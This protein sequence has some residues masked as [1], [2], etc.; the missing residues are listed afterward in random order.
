MPA[1]QTGGTHFLPTSETI[2]FLSQLSNATLK[3]FSSLSISACSVF[4][5]FYE[6]TLHKYTVII[7]H[8]EYDLRQTDRQTD[9]QNRTCCIQV[10]L[11]RQLSRTTW[12]SMS[13]DR[14]FSSS[15]CVQHHHHHHHCYHSQTNS[16]TQAS[17]HSVAIRN[18][19][20]TSPVLVPA[21]WSCRGE[22]AV[23]TVVVTEW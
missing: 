14:A 4:E 6:N 2:V 20:L 23:K 19:E 3:P 22:T 1:H 5:F 7:R 12:S 16:V 8:I 11:R 13:A 10:W 15:T 21:H 9:R 17:G 18:P